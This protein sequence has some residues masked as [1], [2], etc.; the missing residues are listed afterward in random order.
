[1]EEDKEGV[2][3]LRSRW[4]MAGKISEI[5]PIIREEARQD[6][7]SEELPRRRKGRMRT[8]E[9]QGLWT[10]QKRTAT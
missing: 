8:E 10:E 2:E 6:C 9:R 5:D 7:A 3:R 1:M 4:G